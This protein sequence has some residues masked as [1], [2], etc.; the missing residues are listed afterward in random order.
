M[1]A[2]VLWSV[3]LILVI[4]VLDRILLRI[5][6]KGWINYRRS[7]GR[8]RGAWYHMI[9]THSVFDPGIQ[10]VLEATIREERIED[11]SG[12]PPAPD[13]DEPVTQ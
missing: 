1:A 3:G 8:W 4:L 6:A 12:D 7:R 11:E 5:E 9:E 2:W 13:D 10:Q